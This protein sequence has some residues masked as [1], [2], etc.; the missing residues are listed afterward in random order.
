MLQDPALIIIITILLTFIE[1]LLCART[2]TEYRYYVMNPKTT[3][4]SLIFPSNAY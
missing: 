2:I 1:D 4:S 3:V